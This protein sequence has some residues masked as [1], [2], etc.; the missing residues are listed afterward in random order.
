[1]QAFIDINFVP[2]QDAIYLL[3]QPISQAI[4]QIPINLKGCKLHKVCSWT[5]MKL[6]SKLT[7]E[8][9]L[10]NPENSGN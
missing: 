9:L 8:R 6:N 4:K 2:S 5:I 3:K 7:K 1:M 10:K